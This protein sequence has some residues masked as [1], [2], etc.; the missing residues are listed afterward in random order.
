[1]ATE[2]NNN[3]SGAK[4]LS[5][6][7]PSE[8]WELD[9]L[10]EYAKTQHDAIVKGEQTLAPLYWKLGEA[11]HWA[12]KHVPRGH[13]GRFLDKAGIHKVRASKSRAIYKTFPGPEAVANMAV[14]EAYGMRERRTRTATHRTQTRKPTE[15]VP[16]EETVQLEVFLLEVCDRA[17]GLIDVAAFATQNRRAEL[18]PVLRLAIEK[19]T[20]LGRL[21]GADDEQRAEP[22]SEAETHVT[23]KEVSHDTET[24]P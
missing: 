1:M 21:L 19:L 7:E 13:W 14:E 8:S 24:K 23:N 18:C 9:R 20:F 22:T 3:V 5:A 15:D 11:L 10:A 2:D 12:R 17:D 4:P 16:Q 6:D